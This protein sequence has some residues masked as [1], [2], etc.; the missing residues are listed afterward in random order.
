MSDK[1]HQIRLQLSSEQLI[2]LYT[3]LHDKDAES[4]SPYGT[5]F[6][7]SSL[8]SVVSTLKS[9]VLAHMLANLD[10]CK[11][12]YVAVGEDLILPMSEK[13]LEE[14]AFGGTHLPTRTAKSPS[15]YL[16]NQGPYAQEGPD[17]FTDP[18]LDKDAPPYDP[19]VLSNDVSL[20]DNELDELSL[21]ELHKDN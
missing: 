20:I 21:E 12:P 1:F 10:A 18:T 4:V 17:A 6:V 15:D 3:W 2:E 11:K 13:R 7:P 16:K 14:M 9:T 19:R 5:N 8:P